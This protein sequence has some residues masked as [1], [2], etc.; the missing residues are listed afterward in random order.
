MSERR[1]KE[2][3]KM[4]SLFFRKLRWFA[5]S[6]SFDVFSSRFFCQFS[7]SIKTLFYYT[8]QE[9]SDLYFYGYF[10]LDI[11]SVDKTFY[12]L[13]RSLHIKIAGNMAEQKKGDIIFSCTM[14]V[15]SVLHAT[16]MLIFEVAIVE[17]KLKSSSWQSAVYFFWNWRMYILFFIQVVRGKAA[18][19]IYVV[20]FCRFC[21]WKGKWNSNSN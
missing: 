15:Y 21:R 9:G 2:E 10:T 13:L 11:K 3:D 6:S 7:F 20:F 18:Q 4:F 17:I 12:R 19:K 5:S 1:R 16:W 14:Y 8:V